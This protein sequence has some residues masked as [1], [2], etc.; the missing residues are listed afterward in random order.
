[1]ADD[2]CIPVITIDGPGG[3]GKGTIARLIARQLGYQFL[4]SGALY[5]VLA[6]LASRQGVALDDEPALSVLAAGMDIR[7]PADTDSEQVLLEGR[8]VST[9]IRS[10]QAGAGA[11]RVA[12]LPG[13][14]LALLQRQRDFAVAPGLVADGRDMGTV[15]FP[16]AAAKIFLTAGAGVRAQRRCKQLKEKGLPADYNQIL[17]EI[18]ARDERDSSRSVAPLRPADDAFELD[19]SGLDI[20]ATAG[21]V[22][23]F[24]KNRLNP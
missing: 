15:V 7:F 6:L 12:V 14:R 16:A 24:I 20:E 21:R 2:Q 10:E 5:R 11:S 18:Q 22:G 13:V 8:D 3:S 17:A 1:M 23:D 9:E 4:D 19:T